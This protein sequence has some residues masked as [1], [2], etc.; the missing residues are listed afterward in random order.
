MDKLLSNQHIRRRKHTGKLLAS[1]P[2]F[3]VEDS[4]FNTSAK[5]SIAKRK[6]PRQEFSSGNERNRREGW[7]SSGSKRSFS[8]PI[9][10]LLCFCILLGGIIFAAEHFNSLP[11]DWI[12][13]NVVS[14]NPPENGTGDYNMALYNGIALQSWSEV[15]RTMINLPEDA[16]NS[17]DAIPLDLTEMFTWKNY[18]V[19]KGDTVEGIAKA[20]AL[21]I[22]AIIASNNISN[23]RFL[24]EGKTL[25]IPNMDG[26]PYIVKKGDTLSAVSSTL[27]V[28]LEAILDANDIQRDIITP[29]QTIFIPGARM[30]SEDLKLALGDFM[31]YPVKGA[32]LSSAFGWRNDP[33]TGQRTHHA[34]LD[35]AAP[36]GTVVRAASGGSV[37]K[38]GNLPASY[39]KY[40]I[41][42]HG[43]GI[44]TLYAHLNTVGVKQ[45]AKVS[46]GEK[47][48]EVG[49]TGRS[50]GSHLHFMVYKNGRAV[51]PLDFILK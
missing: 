47:I 14:I 9:L 19:K 34:A 24:P 28:P 31:A 43:G 30:R 42:D 51:N 39:G 2:N 10:P 21:S 1:K 36:T 41:L 8:I 25:R 20:H 49:N 37:S 5:S 50:T 6:R 16:A 12:N 23:V 17:E 32:R 46:Q 7:Q 15:G 35:L 27:R 29:G 4:W 40:I 38:T 48:G 18:K 22:D 44:Q 13:R 11:K 45:G 33:F 3:K 26:I